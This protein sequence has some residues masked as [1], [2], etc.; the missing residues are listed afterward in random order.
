[1][2]DMQDN[3][4]TIR[5]KQVADINNAVQSNDTADERTRLEAMYGQ[6]WDTRQMSDA[7][8]PQAFM[9]PY[10]HVRRRSDSV[11]GTLAFQHYPRFYF[12]F[13]SL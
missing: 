5:R 11:E 3:T 12:N 1:M 2:N 13:Q 10:V 6:V 8:A 7:F 9:A 4:E